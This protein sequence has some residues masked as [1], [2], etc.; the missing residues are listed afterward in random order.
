M[1]KK[2]ALGGCFSG[3]IWLGDMSVFPFWANIIT[4]RAITGCFGVRSFYNPLYKNKEEEERKI[5]MKR[6]MSNSKFRKIW[7]VILAVLLVLCVAANIGMNMF[8]AVLDSYLGRGELHVELAEGTEEWDT[9]YNKTTTGSLEEAKAASDEVSEKITDEGIVLLKNNSVLPLEKGTEVTPF[10]YA[11]LNPAYSGTGAAA[12]TDQDMVTAEAGLKNYFT[13]NDAAVERMN[14]GN[15]EYPDAADGTNALD[16]DVNSLQAMMDAGESAKIYEYDPEIYN[17]IETDISDTVGIVY[18][19]RTGSEGIDKRTEG[20]DDGTPHYLALTEN[21]KATIS[22]VK[23]NCSNCIIVLNTA[24]P[25]ELTPVMSGEYEADAI[26]WIGTSGSRGY[27]SLG[28]I[29]SG[30][31]NPSGRLVDI[32]PSDFTKDPTYQNFGD[33]RYTN[34]TVEDTSTLDFIPGANKGTMDRRFVE[35]EEG[36]IYQPLFPGG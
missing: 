8:S 9:D 32:Y 12:T 35:Y 20:Y 28:K 33:Y 24:N 4:F 31:V 13:V 16:Y 7:T 26:L 5:K 36:I 15:A 25:M 22:Y 30:E 18:V 1:G 10:G 19:K 6:K 14:S 3:M 29:M 17:G 21:E 27:E 2:A 23:E 34:S 11:Y